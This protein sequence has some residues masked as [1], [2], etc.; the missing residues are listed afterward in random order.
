M[1]TL[2]I[3]QN[4]S[5]SPLRLL[6]EDNKLLGIWDLTAAQSLADQKGL[7]LVELAS[8]LDPPVCKL[9]NYEAYIHFRNVASVD[10][11]SDEKDVSE[12]KE[13]RLRPKAD[14]SNLWQKI[15]TARNWLYQGKTVKVKIW[16]RG[17][18]R[19]Y[20]ELWND[21]LEFVVHRLVDIGYTKEPAG[22]EDRTMVVILF[23]KHKE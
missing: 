18:E 13:I 12:I 14:D 15:E 21:I 7:D 1:R 17:L 16:F 4:I 9:M 5:A 20:P 2:N 22:P 11:K 8:E 6:D 3:N 10:L 19:Q 23:P